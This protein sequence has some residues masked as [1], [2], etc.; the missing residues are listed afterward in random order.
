MGDLKMDVVGFAVIWMIKRR[1][2][3]V[4]KIISKRLRG[5]DILRWVGVN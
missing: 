2:R 3:E 1:G 4:R 5:F